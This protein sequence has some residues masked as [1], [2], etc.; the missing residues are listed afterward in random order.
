MYV[1]R[2]DTSKHIGLDIKD[3]PGASP[4]DLKKFKGI[5]R[6]DFFPQDKVMNDFYNKESHG[7]G[8]LA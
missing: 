5:R 1:P 6:R 7:G 4:K 3:I 8:S 2:K